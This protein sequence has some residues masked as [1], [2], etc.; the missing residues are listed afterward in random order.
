LG[1]PPQFVTIGI[2]YGAQ[3]PRIGEDVMISGKQFVVKQIIRYPAKYIKVYCT[4]R[5]E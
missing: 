1:G 3:L 5:S 4:R 2:E